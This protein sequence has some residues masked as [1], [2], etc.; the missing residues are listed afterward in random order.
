MDNVQRRKQELNEMTA[1]EGGIEH[2][3]ERSEER[4]LLRGLSS[5]HKE[6]CLTSQGV[7]FE[8]VRAGQMPDFERI[9]KNHDEFMASR[10][11]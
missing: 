11:T 2:M 8:H 7:S 9:H 6:R 10:K 4:D 1:R 3:L 5:Y